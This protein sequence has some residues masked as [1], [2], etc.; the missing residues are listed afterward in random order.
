MMRFRS[1]GSR[2]LNWFTATGSRFKT[3]VDA[4]ALLTA[5]SADVR[6][7]AA[8]GAKVVGDAALT[9]PPQQHRPVER[10]K[11][12]SD[13]QEHSRH[14]RDGQERAVEVRGIAMPPHYGGLSLQQLVGG[15]CR[16]SA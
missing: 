1:D 15:D 16:R 9:V 5:V 10:T 6:A 3:A 7:M 14:P 12:R 8:S 2:A 11:R 13:S 4:N